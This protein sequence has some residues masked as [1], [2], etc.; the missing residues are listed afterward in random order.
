MK[1]STL[2]CAAILI[3]RSVHAAPP[4]G[5]PS[6]PAVSEWFNGL[7]QPGTS[8]PCCSISDCRRVDFRIAI[9]GRYEVLVEGQWYGV[10]NRFVLQQQG[11][12]IGK[13]VACYTANFGY[14]T[15]NGGAYDGDRIEILCFVPELPTS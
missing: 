4:A 8:L 11:N 14:G 15:L 10:P 2:V 13:A 12:P 6:N 3:G 1:P 7:R 9:D 5:L